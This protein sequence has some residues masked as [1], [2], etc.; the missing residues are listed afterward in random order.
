MS[1]QNEISIGRAAAREVELQYG[2]YHNLPWEKKIQ[3][4]G[5]VLAKFAKRKVPY[6]FRILDSRDVNAFALPGG[7]IY[8]NRGML[9]LLNDEEEVAGVLSHELSHVELKHFQQMYNRE[10]T[11][12]I[13]AAV[14]SLATHGSARG[15]LNVA[16][17]INNLVVEPAYSREQ[18]SQADL[19]GIGLMVEAGYNPNGMIDL[20]QG[21]EK[22]GK[23]SSL[24]PT[25]LLDHP[26]LPDRVA[27]I[28]KKISAFPWIPALAARNRVL[29]GT[30]LAAVPAPVK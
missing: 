10:S 30:V 18:E 14:I 3:G 23:S 7:F 1:D 2:V 5:E 13:L 19:N 16:S 17:I 15:V 28:Q 27:A 26:K 9:P 4:V 20:F 6:T 22:E 24:F 25:W 12:S 8:I 29:E 21:M 11:L